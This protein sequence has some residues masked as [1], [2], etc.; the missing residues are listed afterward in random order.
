M[1]R[2]LK[3]IHT[4]VKTTKYLRSVSKSPCHS[5]RA[6][7]TLASV[8]QEFPNPPEGRQKVKLRDYQE[9]CIQSILAYLRHGSRRLGVSLAT[10]SGKTVFKAKD[11]CIDCNTNFP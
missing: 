6:A 7:S 3:C 1:S 11:R 9:E 4:L 5:V 8:S 2:L 10:G